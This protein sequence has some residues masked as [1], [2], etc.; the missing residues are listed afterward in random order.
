[1]TGFDTSPN[2]SPVEAE[3]VINYER[4]AGEEVAGKLTRLNPAGGRSRGERALQMGRGFVE[5]GPACDRLWSPCYA[6]IPL[7]W[8]RCNGPGTEPGDQAEMDALG[9]S[10]GRGHV[11]AD[12]VA[13]LGRLSVMIPGSC[14]SSSRA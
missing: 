12:L 4:R 5:D 7:S 10:L 3:R 9:D 2:L 13:K 6:T 11:P 1:M 14:I 8:N